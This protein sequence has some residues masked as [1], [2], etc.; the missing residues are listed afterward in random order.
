MNQSNLL[1]EKI[2]L[3]CSKPLVPSVLLHLY[4][5]MDVYHLEREEDFNPPEEA[6]IIIID[7]NK[8]EQSRWLSL[9]TASFKSKFYTI[10]YHHSYEGS[11]TPWIVQ[12]GCEAT[13]SSFNFVAFKS[14]FEL[15]PAMVVSTISNP[16]SKVRS[17]LRK[18]LCCL[19]I[20]IQ[21]P[22]A[23]VACKAAL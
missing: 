18:I 3:C 15:I 11:S 6:R 14:I 5:C 21:S 1:K 16:E 9:Q 22:V 23:H 8:P 7:M 2:M 19:S 17:Y 4:Y 13:Y 20:L 10:G 12:V